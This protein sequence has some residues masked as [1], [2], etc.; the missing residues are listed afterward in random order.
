[1][2]SIPRAEWNPMVPSHGSV[3]ID[4]VPRSAMA[5]EERF[6]DTGCRDPMN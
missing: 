1:M 4:K 5:S 2:V 3:M 6:E